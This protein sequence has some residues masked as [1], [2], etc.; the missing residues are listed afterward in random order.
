MTNQFTPLLRK[1]KLGNFIA[2]K[3]TKI[4]LLLNGLH[5]KHCFSLL[6]R[7]FVRGSGLYD[8]LVD[9]IISI[10]S[11]EV[12]VNAVCKTGQTFPPSNC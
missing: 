2:L 5:V 6:H 8:I 4:I 10:I 11:T 7:E 9:K 3:M 12:V 1:I